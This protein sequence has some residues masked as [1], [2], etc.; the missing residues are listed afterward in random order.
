MLTNTGTGSI[1][2]LS[3]YAQA[4]AVDVVNPAKLHSAVKAAGPVELTAGLSS[5]AKV[6]A[7]AAAA[8]GPLGGDRRKE[9]LFSDRGPLQEKASESIMQLP[10]EGLDRLLYAVEAAAAS[11][12]RAALG[13]AAEAAAAAIAADGCR[14]SE[15]EAA[16]D[17]SES[18][19][20]GSQ[21]LLLTLLGA[22]RSSS[23]NAAAAAAAGGDGPGTGTVSAGLPGPPP[24]PPLWA[25]ADMQQLEFFREGC[26]QPDSDAPPAVATW[27]HA[28][29]TATTPWAWGEVDPMAPE[30]AAATRT[31]GGVAYPGGGYIALHATGWGMPPPPPGAQY[32]RLSAP[33]GPAVGTGIGGGSGGA[34]GGEARAARR[35]PS[36]AG[37]VRAA[38]LRSGHGMA[39]GQPSGWTPSHISSGAPAGYGSVSGCQSHP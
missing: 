1:V 33:Q 14:G 12:V 9:A 5:G 15:L 17:G 8:G 10:P 30:S 24:P 34:G 3:G 36:R 35:D 28:A 32:S 22:L 26:V 27:S 19:H 38:S 2:A 29:G 18:R 20:S 6:Q 37:H 16:P 21:A 11:G 13:R 7:A 23:A 4:G 39:G 31:G 25:P